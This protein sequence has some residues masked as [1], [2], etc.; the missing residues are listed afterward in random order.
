MSIQQKLDRV[1]PPR[2]NI[3]YEVAVGDAREKKEL[4]FVVGVLADLS[5]H[6]KDPAK[7]TRL[8][9]RQFTD[10]NPDNFDEVLKKIQPRLKFNVKNMLAKDPESAPQLGVELNFEKLEDFEPQNVVSQVTPLRKLQEARAKLK[11][12]ANDLQGNEEAEEKLYRAIKDPEQLRQLL[13]ELSGP[14]AE[15]ANTEPAQEPQ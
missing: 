9:E 2:V 1:R 11:H 6:P 4:P 7:V 3:T 13:A 14:E 8:R 5:G 10:V 12:L 15:P